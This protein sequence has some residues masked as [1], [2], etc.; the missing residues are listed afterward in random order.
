[1]HVHRYV[2]AVT[3]GTPSRMTSLP[4]VYQLCHISSPTNSFPVLQWEG[5]DLHCLYSYWKLC[6]VAESS[7]LHTQVTKPANPSPP[8]RA[9]AREEGRGSTG[10]DIKIGWFSRSSFDCQQSNQLLT[11]KAGSREAHHSFLKSMCWRTCMQ[12]SFTAKLS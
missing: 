3:I 10:L 1:M 6:K 4:R 12:P 8:S 2:Y 7:W 5:S 11:V 9:T